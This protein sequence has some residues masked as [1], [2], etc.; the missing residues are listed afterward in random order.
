[1]KILVFVGL[2]FNILGFKGLVVRWLIFG[3]VK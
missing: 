2:E 1:M 3:I